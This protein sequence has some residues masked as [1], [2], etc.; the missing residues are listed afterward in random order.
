MSKLAERRKKL[1]LRQ[2]DVARA[3]DVT[4]IAVHNW[5]NGKAYPSTGKLIKLAEILKCDVTDILRERG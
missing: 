5:E 1:N 4:R 3:L 2:I